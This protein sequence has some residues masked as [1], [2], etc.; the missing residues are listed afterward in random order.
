MSP[1]DERAAA[2]YPAPPHVFAL[3]LDDE[4]ALRLRERHHAEEY[5]RRID[6]DRAH[7]ARAFAWGSTATLEKVRGWVAAGLEQFRGG[8]GWAAD[9]CWR[10]RV[11]GSMHLHFL[12]RAG[13]STEIGYWIASAYEGRGLITRAIRGLLRHFYLGRGLAHVSIGLDPRNARSYA[14]AERLGFQPEAVLRRAHIGADGNLADLAFFGLLREEWEARRGPDEPDAPLPLPRFAL[15]AGEEVE[16]ALFERDDIDPLAALVAQNQRHLAAWMPWAQEPSVASIR[17]FV[18]GRALAAIAAADGFEAGIW[19]RGRLVGA[20]GVHD[21]SAWSRR[22]AIGYW[23]DEGAQGHGVVT[24][25]VRAVMARCFQQPFFD[26]QPFQ[27]LDIRADV[28]NA[29]SRAVAERLG[30]TYEGTFRRGM[31]NGREYVDQAV[32]GMLREEWAGRG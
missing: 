22:G 1:V 8:D 7:L 10:G 3:H 2:A 15:R 29:R 9:L 32:Y 4:L 17:A 18:E 20:V 13:G 19:W 26:G 31:F 21:V 14:V 11:V 16:V 25:A 12:D 5:F 24:K 28:A 30:F 27:R 6:A 23:I